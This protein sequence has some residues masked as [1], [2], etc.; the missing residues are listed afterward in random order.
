MADTPTMRESKTARAPISD[1][2]PALSEIRSLDLSSSRITDDGLQLTA[3]L[4]GLRCADL[5]DTGI[6]ATGVD[7]LASLPE[8]E[9]LHLGGTSVGALSRRRLRKAHPRLTIATHA[10][11]SVPPFDGP[12]Y[13]H[14]RLQRRL[15]E[16]G[17]L[18]GA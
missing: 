12:E 10:D 1:N 7:V 6:S 13:E 15:N 16:L 11:Q 3:V 9:W 14:G 17:M 4:T 2:D 8:L 5:R 18:P